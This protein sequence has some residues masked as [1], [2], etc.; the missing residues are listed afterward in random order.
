[1]CLFLEEEADHY[2][3]NL[4]TADEAAIIILDE[5][6]RA[7]FCDIVLACQRSENNAPIFQNISSTTVVYMPLHYVLFFLCRDFWM[8]LGTSITQS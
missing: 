1:M 6:D 5:Y 8:A 7:S 4:L 3:N 2:C